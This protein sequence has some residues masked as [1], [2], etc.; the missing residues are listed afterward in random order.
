MFRCSQK[1][2][3]RYSLLQQPSVV[4]S[5]KCDNEGGHRNPGKCWTLATNGSLGM[6][7]RLSGSHNKVLSPV[8]S[9]CKNSS[10][11]KTVPEHRYGERCE[12]K[13]QD[14][15]VGL[16]L[17]ISCYVGR[18]IQNKDW[19]QAFKDLV[20]SHSHLLG[21]PKLC[22]V[23]YVQQGQAVKSRKVHLIKSS[24]DSDDD[25]SISSSDEE[26]ERKEPVASPIDVACAALQAESAK[27][28]G[29]LLNQ[30]AMVYQRRKEY[31][32][33][34]HLF[35]A[36]S[37]KGHVPSLFNIGVCYEKGQG[38]GRSMKTAAEF[39][40]RAAASGH[41]EAM[42][43]VASIHYEQKGY[44]EH[45]SKEAGFKLM[46]E[47]ADRGHARACSFVALRYAEEEKWNDAFT[48]FDKAA[49][50]SND[51]QHQQQGMALFNL[52]MCFEN[53]LGTR[54]DAV[55]AGECYLRAAQ[56]GDVSSQQRVGDGFYHGTRG[57]RKD[58]GQALRWLRTAASNGSEEAEI[59]AREVQRLIAKNEKDPLNIFSFLS[60]GTIIDNVKEKGRD[61]SS[62]LRAV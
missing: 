61:I 5:S 57:L 55:R 14:I 12:Q 33:A 59:A 10:L 23:T 52:A 21:I 37:E 42:W 25:V 6:L 18:K 40:D 43:N 19:L 48:Y 36:A 29:A 26:D 58:F 24:T 11:T 53:G 13:K 60:G 30:Y 9:Q 35:V 8:L 39:Y 7:G 41:T 47:A 16:M 4:L 51:Q 28:T 34:F 54:T 3:K 2:V 20:D 38:V 46:K 50:T 1:L 27:C 31:S 56:L 44:L 62:V 17:G 22:P 15:L 49:T 45:E 32:T